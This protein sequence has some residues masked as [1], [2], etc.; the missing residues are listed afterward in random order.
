MSA[1]VLRAA[2]T[3]LYAGARLLAD[4]PL[5]S[6]TGVTVVYADLASA[7]ARVERLDGGRL[8]LIVGPHRTARGTSVA[9]KRW[10]VEPIAAVPSAWRVVRRLDAAPR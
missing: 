9:A 8:Q 1:A 2:H 4:G 5:A 6:R 3:H 7:P 10:L